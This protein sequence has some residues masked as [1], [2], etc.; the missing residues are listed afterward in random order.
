[1]LFFQP[2]YYSSL[3]SEL[4]NDELH[5]DTVLCS[6]K[7]NVFVHSSVI[8]RCSPLLNN[9]LASS[10]TK[11]VIL[12]GFSSVLHDLVTLVYTGT[13]TVQTGLDNQLLVLLC[14]ELGMKVTS[15]IESGKRDTKK[16]KD[17]SQQPNCLKVE[18]EIFCEDSQ[19]IFNLRMPKCR[20]DRKN[21]KAQKISHKLDGFRGRIQEEFNCS[22]VGPYEGPYDQ[23]Q[24]IPLHAQL[25]KS[26]LDFKQYT[27]FSHLN[28]SQ[29][30]ILKINKQYEDMDDLKKID[31]LEILAEAKEPFA[32]EKSDEEVFYTCTEN[33]CVIPC[34]CHQC[35]LKENQCSMHKIK[36]IDL[37]NEHEHAISVRSTDHFCYKE[38]FFW[39]SYTLKYPG[40]PKDCI[41]CTRDLLHHKCYH[42]DFHRL[43]K[44]CKFYEYKLFPKTVEELLAREEAEKKWYKS[45]CPFCDRKFTEP[46]TTKRHIELEHQ[47]KKLTC[48]ECP[49]VCQ[50][51]QSVDY[52]KLTAHTKN[53]CSYHAC[54]LC[55][56]TF[57][58]KI[59]L[60]NHTKFVHTANVKH[61]ACS[62]CDSTFKHKKYLNAHILHVHGVNEQKEDYWQDIPRQTF[63]CET[64]KARFNRKADL[65]V[66]TKTKHSGIAILECD[67]CPAKFTYKKTL[68]RH[69]MENHDGGRKRFKCDNCGELFN[70]KRNMERHQMSHR[71]K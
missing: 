17:D 18:T 45:V 50:C 57:P 11:T 61:L 13:V 42:I 38:T 60:N 58:S 22:P 29:C 8:S 54:Q 63:V 1:M 64:C 68:N 27:T 12:P 10:T 49:K 15:D 33:F 62:K 5:T 47:S 39:H 36:H 48:N 19:D 28:I 35:Y 21:L 31:A 14:K 66:H 30:K 25:S 52:H 55:D 43:C 40:I 23:N 46:Y 59:G 3:L 26:S 7:S 51:K 4:E 20:I 71:K 65:K 41:Q 16:R 70:Q 2:G 69:K 56:K 9:L 34:V 53:H 32:K 37:F 67:Q 24:K 44:F 6:D